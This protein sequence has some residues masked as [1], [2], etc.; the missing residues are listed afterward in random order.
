MKKARVLLPLL[1]VAG[2]GTSN[3]YLAQK[4]TTVE[5]YHIFDIKTAA[6]TGAIA[7][8]ATDG[9]GKNTGSV[10]SDTP[11]QLAVDVPDKPGRFTIAGAGTGANAD[12]AGAAATPQ[13]APTANGGA[14]LKTASCEGAAW[15]GRAVRTTAFTNK[16]TLHACLYKYKEG[17][18]LDTY[19]VFQKTE[20]GLAQLPRNLTNRLLGSS[21]EWV[22]KTIWSMV[23]S[24]EAAAQAKATH[25]EGQPQLGPAPGAT[26]VAANAP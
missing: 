11:L 10:S 14:G 12:P 20:G 16:L 2:C 21:E 26:Q 22:N 6:P 17:Y 1:L 25:V 7:R 4:S 9:L 13:P 24:V 5:M 18:Q 23:R 19:T 15:T 8:A 3:N